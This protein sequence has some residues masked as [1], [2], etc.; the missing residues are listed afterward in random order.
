MLWG[1][2]PVHFDNW[3]KAASSAIAMEASTSSPSTSPIC[4]RKLASTPELPLRVTRS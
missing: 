4:P 2:Q 3:N 1:I